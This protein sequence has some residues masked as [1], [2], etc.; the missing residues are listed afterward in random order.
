MISVAVAIDLVTRLRRDSA[1]HFHF[2][3]PN[4]AELSYA[5]CHALE[6]RRGPRPRVVPGIAF[7][8]S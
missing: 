6:I 8:K 4:R 7:R 3:T 2:Y 1:E 5:I